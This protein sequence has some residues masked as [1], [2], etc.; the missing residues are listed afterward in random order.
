MQSPLW[1]IVAS[2]VFVTILLGI[3]LY[4]GVHEWLLEVLAW[5]EAQGAWAAVLFV[6]IM[7]AAVVLTLPGIF[8]TTGAGFVFGVVQGSL[9]VVVGTTLGAA[10]AFLIARHLLGSRAT[11]FILEHEQLRLINAEMARHGWK[12]VLLTRMIPFF[13]SK[14]ANYFYGLT[15]FRFRGYLLGSFLGFIPFSVHNVYL[16]SIV[17]DL[18]A[19]TERD[20]GRTP[21]EWTLY[22]LGFVVTIIAVIYFNRLARRALAGYAEEDAEIKDKETD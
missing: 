1:V 2:V 16:G 10:I 19:I 6:L 15:T 7:A 11:R 14:V 9:L 17:G 3:L 13:P 21:V 18:A 5:V 22:G 8:L 20:L 4:F 12:V